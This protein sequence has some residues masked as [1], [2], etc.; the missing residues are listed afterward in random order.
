LASFVELNIMPLCLSS[1]ER[2]LTNKFFSFSAATVVALAVSLTLSHASCEEG[3]AV[4]G[5]AVRE[6][7]KPKSSDAPAQ[8][9][10]P[11]PQWK[12]GDPIRLKRQPK[13]S[14]QPPVKEPAKDND[15]KDR[16]EDKPR[17]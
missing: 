6:P 16:S 2:A 14:N 10:I 11:A 15:K 4:K 17:E 5:P 7:V 8:D 12:P 1:P 9:L 13:G 3:P